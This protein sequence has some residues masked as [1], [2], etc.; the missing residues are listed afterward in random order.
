[1]TC[2]HAQAKS[3]RRTRVLSTP[4]NPRVARS[5]PPA[6]PPATGAHLVTPHINGHTAYQGASSERTAAAG[7]QIRWRRLRRAPKRMR[8]ALQPGQVGSHS[9]SA[10]GEGSAEWVVMTGSLSPTATLWNIDPT[11]SQ[12]SRHSRGAVGS[13][14][15]S[16]EIWAWRPVV[17]R[18]P[19]RGKCTPLPSVIR[20]S[21]GWM[22]IL[23]RGHL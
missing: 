4:E 18:A 6:H 12:I 7:A 14:E 2:S 13:D 19:V 10:Y 17:A 22:A 20:S 15:R 21:Y 5:P 9:R 11:I 16:L 1:M 3:A 8:T 23:P